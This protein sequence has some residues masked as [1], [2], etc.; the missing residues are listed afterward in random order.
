MFDARH[1]AARQ[2]DNELTWTSPCLATPLAA[3]LHMLLLCPPL[4]WEMEADPS[5]F[6]KLIQENT[7]FKS[8]TRSSL[9]MAELTAWGGIGGTCL[10]MCAQVRHEQSQDSS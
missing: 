1:A 4:T 3:D 10:S 7:S 6:S 5:G 9:Q 2:I 8:L